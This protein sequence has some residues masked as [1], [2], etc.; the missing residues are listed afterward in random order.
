MREW[1]WSASAYNMQYDVCTTSCISPPLM[2]WCSLAQTVNTY[3][4]ILTSKQSLRWL[5]RSS[6]RTPPTCTAGPATRSHTHTVPPLTHLQHG[7]AQHEHGA[8]TCMRAQSA[9]HT[10]ERY[11]AAGPTSAC[12][13][14]RSELTY[15]LVDRIQS[16]RR[17][18]GEARTTSPRKRRRRHPS[19][20]GGRRSKP[21]AGAVTQL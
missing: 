7:R 17:V 15:L 4:L 8:C 10:H 12:V 13:R 20:H 3:G 1:V 21:L 16:R 5:G 14:L 11:T 9:P 6:V 18:R 19:G 2:A